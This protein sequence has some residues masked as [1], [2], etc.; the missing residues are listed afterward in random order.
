M[1]KTMSLLLALVI[2]FTL[3]LP[4][5]S[6]AYG[7]AGGTGATMAV[8]DL[9]TEYTNNPIGIDV[10]KPRMSWK[11]Q[12]DKR[13]QLQTAYAIQVASTNQKLLDNQ[14]DVWN[15]DKVDSNQSVNVVYDGKPLE[16]GKRY[17]WRVKVWDLNNEKASEW[18]DPAWWEMGLLHDSDWQADWIG[19]SDA[20]NMTT[21]GLKWVWFPEG[22]PASNAPAGDR[23]FRKTIQLPLDRTITQGKF[24]LTA[25][26]GFV[27]YVNGKR[28]GSSI[29]A[30][31]SWKEGKI[32]DVSSALIPGSNTIAIQTSN[33]GGPA[34]LLGSLKVVFEEGT[35]LQL[36][37]DQGLKAAKVKMEGWEKSDFDDSSWSA[38]M[39]VASYGESPWG[40]NVKITASPP[41]IRK[42]F[43][44][45]KSIAKARLYSSALGIYEPSINGKR[46]GGDLF[47]PGWT[48]YTKH[49]QY[50]TYDVTDLLQN[51]DNVIGAILAEGWYSG[52]VGF[53]GPNIYGDSNYLFMQLNLEY[54]DGSTETI[55]TDQSWK[56]AAGPI[57][58]SSIL[59][60]E[61]YD[62][63]KELDGWDTPAFDATSWDSVQKLEK[64]VTGKLVAQDGPTVQLIEEMKPIKMTEPESGK[65]V[66]DLGQNMVGTV[67]LKVSGEAGQ[68]VTLRHAEVLNPDG[69]FYTAN[70]R[71]AK[72]T[73]RYTLKGGGDEVYEPKF[74]FHG[75]RYVEVTGY[76]GVPS[77]D[78]VTGQVMHTAAPFS[79]KLET[80]SA[81][82]NQL[83]SNITWGQ[84]GNFLEVPTDTPAR[85]ERL[86]W[87]GD[88][89]VFIGAAAFNMDVAKF[90]GSK[91]MR[92]LRDGQ[93][94]NGAFPDVAPNVLG[95]RGNAGWGDAGVT[96]P[97]TIWQRYGDIRVIEE[98]YD[99]MVHWIEYM[100]KNSSGLIRPSSMY[101]DWLDVND[102]TPG[103]LISTAYF[104]Y[105]TK[106][107]SEMGH[108][109]GR[110][111]DADKYEQLYGQVKAAFIKAYV[112]ED[113]K[114]KGN[115]QTG[116]VL[117]LYM[118]LV[119][120]SKRQAAADHLVELI[121]ARDW[122]LSTGFLGT[123]DLLP[124]LSETGHLDVAYRLL[125]ND[126]YPSWGYQIKNGA[127]TMWERWDS[128]KPDGSF[129]DIGMNSFNHYAYGA[130]GDWM[131]QN[132]A[133]IQQDPASPGYKHILIKPRP[134]GNLTSAK[135]S[136]NS[137]YGMIVSDWK[138]EGDIFSQHVTIPTN[139][140]ATVYI[141]TDSKWAVT[142]SG[143]FA[144]SVEGVQFV[145]MEEGNAVFTVGSGDYQFVV[146]PIIGDLGSALDEADKFQNEVI[147]YSNNG[148]LTSEQTQA[149]SSKGEA[150]ASRI[151]ASIEA[152]KAGDDALFIE[153]VHH[154][155]YETD[156]L[157]QWLQEQSD[158]GSI[159]D[160][161][162]KKLANLISN[163]TTFLSA[164]SNEKL[165]IKWLIS[166]S[167]VS[168]L[169]GN[170]FTVE[171]KA[172]NDGDASI[173]DVRYTLQKP[174]GWEVTSIGD[175]QTSVIK[176]GETFAAAFRVKVSEQQQPTSLFNIVGSGS[177]KINDATVEV[178]LKTTIKIDSPIII[179][180]LKAEPATIEPS[181]TSTVNTTIQNKG[182]F[183]VEGS[184]ELSAPLNWTVSPARQAYSLEAGE[185]KNISFEVKSPLLAVETAAELRAIASFHGA[186][187]A[188]SSTTIQVR[189][190]NPPI[191]FYDHVD[192][193]EQG[194][195]QKHNVK[196]SA[197][198]GANVEE[199]L[200][201]RYVNHGDA[202]G[203]FQFDMTVE[204]GKPFIIRAIETYDR[205]QLKD[206]YVLVNGTK[207]L[208]RVNEKDSRGIVTYQFVVDDISLTKDGKVT[209]RFQ[210]DEEGRNYDPSIADVW[211]M[212]LNAEYVSL[213]DIPARV[214][215][216]SITIAGY[217]TLDKVEVKVLGPDQ[218]MLYRKELPG[219]V[220]SDSYSIAKDASPGTYTVV[221]GNGT[222]QAIKRFE[223]RANIPVTELKLDRSSI[224]LKDGESIEISA[225][226]FPAN[227]TN[228]NVH[229]VSNHEN[230]VVTN[231]HYD[232]ANLV[233]KAT[234]TATNKGAEALTGL[235]TATTEEG[236]KTAAL[237][238]KV[239]TVAS[240]KDMATL[241]GP[242]MVLAGQE[243]EWTIGTDNIS[244]NFTALDVVF[245]YDPQK[246]EFQTV[247]EGVS[248]AL[249]PSAIQSLK[250]NFAVLGSAVKPEL[251]QIRIIMATS[252]EQRGGIDGG[253]LFSLHGKVKADAK[254]GS[255]TVSL[256]DFEV[257]LNGKGT[258][259]N[260]SQAS[261]LIEV[262]LAD[263]TALNAAIQQ[264]ESAHDAAVEGTLP[265]QY[266]IGAKAALQAAINSAIAVKN[267]ANATGEEIAG[268]LNALNAAMKRFADSVIPS[269][270]VDRTVLN[271]AIAA[272]QTKHDRA[273]EGTKVGKYAAGSKAALQ[274]AINTAKNAGS[275]Q[276]QVDEAVTL[277]NKAVQVFTAK[278]V[279]LIEGQTKVTIRDLSIIAKFY[280]VTSADPRWSEIEKAD[281]LG[282]NAID[283]RT[284]AAVAQM[285]LDE[286]RKE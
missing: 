240:E 42:G 114:V 142:E 36:N 134:G 67:R 28:M 170:T 164:I 271:A 4:M 13:G 14:P 10:V 78:A 143:Q 76:P 179:K 274:A 210:E 232:E 139:T 24:L 100:R 199:G 187:A 269:I 202:N 129:Q 59:M 11:L 200:T 221:A 71:A 196:F 261:L 280:G 154:A 153:Q 165:G 166:P 176:P 120:E 156:G 43:S 119:P 237:N 77:M 115:S 222:T 249:D 1:R 130:V 110:Q 94:I 281:V 141:P 254:A 278:I 79:G 259:M 213:Q 243:A 6:T 74:T 97:Y 275:S 162:V 178:P 44:L 56:W 267:D 117:A 150:L 32:V 172:T 34:G 253:P 262:N 185:E 144:L 159:N 41:Y 116:Y 70:L 64:E 250:P 21:E 25:D 180:A 89:N 58:S 26:D 168:V 236:A 83:Q 52:H 193:G 206:Y 245:H 251:G 216:D 211:T 128:I 155:L 146:D 19:M 40:K 68:T 220:F 124:V 107:V 186:E 53:I 270:P 247:K 29:K 131:Y 60:G 111:E 96:V 122:H 212:P 9:T 263:K 160:A 90:I 194:S 17:F 190:K 88:I 121:K 27:L 37:M 272:A 189:Y 169:P 279:T 258:I 133:G 93:S 195:E 47:T 80:S 208:S 118:D 69:T 85:D 23:Y 205:A 39:I 209:V 81:M 260:V 92:D 241:S 244:S 229:F 231:V 3:C 136:Y 203:Y 227:A 38:A 51:G 273:V 282:I 106:L 197:Q 84:R 46:V 35:P 63:T 256:S 157:Q 62:A 152:Y 219:G 223:V 48:D 16:S 66:F 239:T 54:T 214:A 228:K 158:T 226:V 7:E 45:E 207:V 182:S 283:I 181:G 183:S 235:I 123:R 57:V 252:G 198:S 87:T 215:G 82:L 102:P 22:N 108:A 167:E 103:D 20:N 161:I 177:Y 113:G 276:W 49:I 224:E 104:A 218:A 145:G 140:T 163:A 173:N 265:G 55:G 99:E 61:T 138:K 171:V 75:F 95:E 248:Q 18:S 285:I 135:G 91:W 137:V 105:S 12:S 184:I 31:D 98:N 147:S 268:T 234:V 175:N 204:P 73:D 284:L 151:E 33:D 225:T 50:Q 72:A 230:I 5:T 86:G 242:A 127:T 126:T 148:E 233:T 125:N 255:T 286:W 2:G 8:T 217:T 266:P 238:V 101:G 188:K 112:S 192:V 174:E 191:D 277:L 109:I 65:Y 246:F 132:I 149:L 201:R 15:T 257:S 30:V 264:A